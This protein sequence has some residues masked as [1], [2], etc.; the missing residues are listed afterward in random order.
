MHQSNISSAE[1][2][3]KAQKIKFVTNDHEMLELMKQEGKNIPFNGSMI[4]GLDKGFTPTALYY[5]KHSNINHT[6][7][8]FIPA[9]QYNQPN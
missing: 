9:S 4:R 1:F 5:P 8:K 2:K 3:I 6:G 7:S